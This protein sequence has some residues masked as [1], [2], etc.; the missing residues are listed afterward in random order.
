[1]LSVIPDE[2]NL[3]VESLSGVGL[4]R[5]QNLER[6]GIRTIQDLLLHRP[7]RYEDRRHVQTIRDLKDCKAGTARG[8]IVA[9]GAKTFARGAK[10]V[11]EI[12]LDD[13]TGRLH[14]RW[15]NLPFMRN[16]FA[17]GDDL[18]VYGKFV[19]RKPLTI[20]HPEIEIIEDDESA[21]VHVDRIAPIY[22]LT[23]GITQRYLRKLLW[24]VLRRKDLRFSI[25]PDQTVSN[26]ETKT[27][28]NQLHFPDSLEEAALAR[29]RLAFWEFLDLQIGIQRRRALWRLRSQALPCGGTNHLMKPFLKG[30]G[31]ELTDSQLAV[32]R[33][34]RADLRGTA[35]MR[36][37]LQGDVG[38]GKTVVAASSALMAIESGYNVLF[39]APTELIALQHFERLKLWFNPLGVSVGIRTAA[40]KTPIDLPKGKIGALIV[41]THALLESTFSMNDVGLVIIDEQHKFG[42]SQRETLLKKGHAPHLLM[43]TATPIPRTLA[44]L[45][46]SD[47][48]HSI[49]QES[50][51]GRGT[52]KTVIRINR[53]TT[54]L[55]KFVR[56]EL[57][58]GKQVYVV[59]PRVEKDD[60]LESKGAKEE[61]ERL[62]PL[63]APA[64]SELLYSSLP[65]ETK[66]R[67]TSDFRK[68]KIQALIATSIVEVGLDVENATLMIVMGAEQFGLSQLHQLR[69]RVGRGPCDSL[70]VLLVNKIEAR[71]KLAILTKCQNGFEVAEEDLRRRGPGEILGQRQAGAASLRFA[72][73]AVDLELMNQARLFAGQL[74]KF[75]D[76][77]NRRQ[78]IP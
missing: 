39:M 51:K 37:L 77:S 73:F 66:E 64:Q 63:L 35:P 75:S 57:L 60:R 40:A 2:L 33:E 48:D 22:P 52:I 19:Q 44:L 41:G 50:P 69:G 74:I 28:I 59:L 3:P 34:I 6:L 27:I 72:D 49:I 21:R 54:K 36:R 8:K 14:C 32:L 43:M 47:L 18:F 31:F 58:K 45:T 16:Y 10:S 30:L 13:G 38:S 68:N 25:Y 24:D 15:W 12:I 17:V 26:R 55:W 1:V 76:D 53:N 71:E 11:F 61:F 78:P 62:M 23:E 65:S 29:E 7:R 42:V 56:S 5:R 9:L 4:D 46:H 70:C 20:D 67:I